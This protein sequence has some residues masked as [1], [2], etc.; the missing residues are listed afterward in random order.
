MEPGVLLPHP[1][2]PATCLYL[3][4]DQSSLC[5]IPLLEDPSW[6]YNSVYVYV[7]QV[8]SCPQVSPP[9]HYAPLLSPIR[10]TCP[11]H[12][13]F[14]NLI[15][16]IIYGDEY[17]WLSSSLCSLL[18]SIIAFVPLRPTYLF[19]KPLLEHP[20]PVFLPQC[21][22]PSFAPVQDRRQNYRSI[23]LMTANWKIKDFAQN[24]SKHFLRSVCS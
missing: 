7:F 21:E 1:Q 18:H 12:P 17:R 13:I 22:R 23:C 4:P 3:E 2:V 9:K 19:K 14:L 8:V 10:A 6:Y 24:D 16:W 15:T 5:P 11:V 20:K